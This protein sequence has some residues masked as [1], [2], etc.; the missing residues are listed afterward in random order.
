MFEPAA[1]MREGRRQLGRTA[2]AVPRVCLLDPD[3]DVVRYLRR[4]E[5]ASLHP[6]WSCYHTE[7]WTAEH[8]G[9]TFGVV[10]CAVGAPFAVLVA[11]QLAAADA[12]SS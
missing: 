3:G 5:L 4:K 10:G 9:V 2:D 8:A 12:N 11:E 6:G 7:L 1:L